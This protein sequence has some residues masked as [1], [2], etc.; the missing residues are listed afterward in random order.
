MKA[1]DYPPDVILSPIEYAPMDM[2]RADKAVEINRS[3]RGN[4]SQ[5]IL[6]AYADLFDID[7][8]TAYAIGEG[9]SSGFG[10]GEG[11]CGALGVTA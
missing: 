10:S 4:C 6:M 9:L 5:S 2:V 3:R 7:Q 8:K 1:D 11:T